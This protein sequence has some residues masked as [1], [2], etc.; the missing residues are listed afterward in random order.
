MLALSNLQRRDAAGVAPD[1]G[2]LA[3]A[4]TS[5]T[6][7]RGVCPLA[8]RQDDRGGRRSRRDVAARPA[9]RQRQVEESPG[10]SSR[11]HHRS[12]LASGTQRAG[13]QRR[14]RPDLQR[15][16]FGRRVG[17]AGRAV[18]PERDGGGESG[19]ASGRRDRE[20]EKLRRPRDLGRSLPVRPRGSPA[21]GR[22]SSTSTAGRSSA[23]GRATSDEATISATS[24]E[25][26]S[27]IRTS[28]AR[29]AS[30][31]RSRS[32]TTDAFARTRSRTSARCSTGSRA[33]RTRQGSRDDRRP[34][35]R[36]V[37]CAGLR[38]C[39]SRPPQRRESRLRDHRLSVVPRI[40]RSLPAGQSQRRVPA[41]PRTPTCARSSPAS[42]R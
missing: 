5:R 32:S 18:D 26:P 25:S 23:N 20:V 4:F 22:S 28:G 41:I 33:A 36:R 12:D 27:S 35:L 42:R 10:A 6:G 9:R 16:L 3:A 30:A 15:R 19:V 39:V 37:H 7:H 38:H 8:G 13:V 29:P 1:T 21:P 31:A 24:S 14:R 2:E 17:R 11:R 40:D 34:Q